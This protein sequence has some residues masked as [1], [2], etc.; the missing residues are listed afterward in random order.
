MRIVMNVVLTVVLVITGGGAVSALASSDETPADRTKTD[1]AKVDTL[2]DKLGD[3]ESNAVDSAVEV[4]LE[5]FDLRSA[6]SGTVMTTN[7]PFLRERETDLSYVKVVRDDFDE[8]T[9]IYGTPVQLSSAFEK[10]LVGACIQVPYYEDGLDLYMLAFYH[11][12]TTGD[13]S[14]DVNE[15]RLIVDSGRVQTYPYPWPFR[16]HKENPETRMCFDWYI[17][18]LP[19]AEEFNKIAFAM[20]VR[21]KYG[22]YEGEFSE[23]TFALLR[24]VYGEYVKAV[25]GQKKAD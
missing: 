24:E 5:L 23:S 9:R 21:Y 16:G 19:D 13:S 20:E 3:E 17:L 18:P 10:H 11:L 25:A 15:I 7:N 4:A 6:D 12:Y 22:D 2:R 1:T 8:C 14:M